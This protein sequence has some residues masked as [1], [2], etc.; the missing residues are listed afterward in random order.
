MEMPKSDSFLQ[1]EMRDE[2]AVARFTCPVILGGQIADTFGEKLNAILPELGQRHL[3]VDFANVRSVTSLML[4]KLVQLNNAASAMGTRLV[5]F[6]ISPSVRKIVEV[7]RLD[8][9]LTLHEDE[10]SALASRDTG[11]TRTTR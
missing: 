11:S 9:L 7:T 6:N 3:M 1:V 8:M 4:G 5:L 10:A 2:A